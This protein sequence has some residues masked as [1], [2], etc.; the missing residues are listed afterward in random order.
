VPFTMSLESALKQAK[1]DVPDIESPLHSVLMTANSVAINDMAKESKTP[2]GAVML[3][4]SDSARKEVRHCSFRYLFVFCVVS[5]LGFSFLRQSRRL[6]SGIVNLHLPSLVSVHGQDHDFIVEKARLAGDTI[7]DVST[8]VF[9]LLHLSLAEDLASWRAY[10][11][12]VFGICSAP[13]PAIIE[14]FRSAIVL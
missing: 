13:R 8:E 10:F 9:G 14:L 5:F 12:S 2:T 7:I 11:R 6:M 1:L 3:C 4:P